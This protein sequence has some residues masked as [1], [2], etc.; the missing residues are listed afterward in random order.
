MREQGAN[1]L[2]LNQRQRAP[3]SLTR[4]GQLFADMRRDTRDVLHERDRVFKNVVVDTLKNPALA[5]SFLNEYGAIG[6]ID[7]ASANCFRA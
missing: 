3:M 2:R 6:I 7:V 4:V 5:Q 1:V